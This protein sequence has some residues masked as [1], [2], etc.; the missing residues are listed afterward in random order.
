MKVA[1]VSQIFDQ[2]LPPQ[3]N[4]VG[5]WTY[6]VARRLAA[7]HEILV[8][9]RAGSGPPMPVDGSKMRLASI[10]CVPLGAWSRAARAWQLLAPFGQPLYA[11]KF[12]GLDYLLGALWQLRR[13]DPDIIHLQNF[14]RHVPAIRL[15]CPRAAIVLHMH[16]DWLTELNARGMRKGVVAADLVVGCSEHVIGAARRRFA[17]TGIA[18]AVLPNGAS[19][20][21][22]AA[23]AAERDA[24][25]VVFV[26]RLSPEKGLHTL[27][28]A[29]QKVIAARP[30]LRLEIIGPVAETPRAFL[31]DLSTEPA[32]RALARFYRGG[33]SY[34]GTYANAL[35]AMIPPQLAHTVRFTNYLPQQKVLERISR[36]GLLV[37]PSLSESFGMSVIE[38]ISVGTPVIVTRTGGM[39]EIIAATGTG[40]IV[41][42]NDPHALAE[43][44]VQVV[45]DHTSQLESARRGSERAA[46]LYSWSQIASQTHGLHREALAA[47]RLR[48]AAAKRSERF[49]FLRRA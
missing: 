9:A 30:E 17:S 34:A 36:A 29:W 32:V 38:A 49:G 22:G 7:R 23:G 24:G 26:G 39:P 45:Q 33:V 8:I 12:Y 44:I 42:K 28:E 15:A 4:S 19:V 47:R 20:A 13:F 46:E 35:R 25:T 16:C 41:A 6:E 14:P 11:Q 10:K 27:L 2:V 1:F 40:T 37:N 43:A 48:D 5:I 21:R 31:V 3:Q 18:L